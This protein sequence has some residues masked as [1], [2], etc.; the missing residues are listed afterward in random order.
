MKRLSSKSIVTL[1]AADARAIT[2][3][4]YLGTTGG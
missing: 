1:R 3:A 2:S 4:F